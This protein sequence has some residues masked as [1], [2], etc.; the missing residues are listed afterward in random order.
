MSAQDLTPR[1]YWPAPKGTRIASI[2]Y[3]HV[4]GDTI[5]D[6]SLPITG[7][8]SKINSIRLGYLETVELWGRTANIVLELPYSDGT[9]KGTRD[10]NFDVE[11]YYQGL[12]D[13]SATVSVNLLGAP[14]MT[15]QDFAL[16][17]AEPRPIIGAS[18]KLVAPTGR[19]DSKR[20]INVGTNRWAARAE[21]G[22]VTPMG[23]RWMFEA[24]LS[25][26][27][28]A[29]NNDF[30]GLTR[31]QSPIAAVQAHVVHRFGPGFW[32]SLDGSFYHGGRSKVGGRRL[33]D[34]Q[35]DGKLG[36]T[37][38]FPIARKHVLKASYSTGSV[39]DSD[40]SF[41]TLLLGYS[42]IF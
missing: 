15:K 27:A 6:P 22:L 19:Y 25:G 28:F 41:D 2:G 29:D 23:G 42:H 4:S 26:W 30:L 37:L 9:T 16:L 18:L 7:V 35:R 31:E 33:D 10:D 39:N 12:G 13:V 32:A 21:L 24:A 34:L 1:A 3:V 8:D 20:I 38:V 11:R 36:I 17:R 40:E 14:S 5:P